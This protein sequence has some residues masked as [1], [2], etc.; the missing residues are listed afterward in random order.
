MTVLRGEALADIGAVKK[1]KAVGPSEGKIKTVC[2]TAA[3]D[4][5]TAILRPPLARFRSAT[6]EK[7]ARTG[8]D[9]GSFFASRTRK[10]FVSERIL[11][12]KRTTPHN[13]AVL[14]MPY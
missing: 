5:I 11:F 6:R 9:S 8:G 10:N 2:V 1:R 3:S 14:Y 13:Q 12:N 7:R 4:A